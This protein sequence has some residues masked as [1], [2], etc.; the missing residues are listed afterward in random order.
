V[1]ERTMPPTHEL[2]DIG[3]DVRDLIEAVRSGSTVWSA[4]ACNEDSMAELLARVVQD[5]VQYG[6]PF[7][8]VIKLALKRERG[9]V[10]ERKA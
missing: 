5:S 2:I 1:G 7:E 3:A 4:L 10:R 8:R 9:N 6:V